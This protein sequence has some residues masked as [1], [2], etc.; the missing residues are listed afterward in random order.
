MVVTD[1]LI[2]SDAARQANLAQPLA[3][4]V[5]R[6][7]DAARRHGLEYLGSAIH[8]HAPGW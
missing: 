3:D 6:C 2:Q 5:A 8:L 4:L 1:Y 7:R